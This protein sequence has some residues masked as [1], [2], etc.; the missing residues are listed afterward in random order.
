M[1]LSNDD[2]LKLFEVPAYHKTITERLVHDLNPEN[3]KGYIYSVN[4]VKLILS[5]DIPEV[6]IKGK[7]KESVDKIV[8]KLCRKIKSAEEPSNRCHFY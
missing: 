3:K 1:K 8:R 6:E 4:G 5:K 7:E 2:V